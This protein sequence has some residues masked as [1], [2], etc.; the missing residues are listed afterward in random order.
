MSSRSSTVGPVDRDALK[1]LTRNHREGVTDDG[2]RYEYTRPDRDKYPAQFYWDSCFHAFSLARLKPEWARAELRSLVAAQESSGFIGHT[3]FWDAPIRSSRRLFYNVIDGND[4]MTRTIQPP[5]LALAWEAVAQASPDDPGFLAEGIA[6]LIAHYDW[7][8]RER[9]PERVCLLSIIQPDESGLD[10]SP[11]FDALLSWRAAGYP[12]FVALVQRN[13]RDHFELGRIKARNGFVV[14]EVL[15]N[16]A[17]ALSLQALARL[18]GEARFAERAA[19]VRDALIERCYDEQTGLFFDRHATGLQKVSTWTSVA[20][21]ALPDLDP[22][23]AE[24]LIGEHVLNTNEFWLPF[25]I[26]SASASERSFKPFTRLLRYW[27]GPTWMPC[28]WLIH[29]GLGE[30]GRD[31]A[32]QELAGRVATLVARHGFREYYDPYDGRGMGAGHFGMSTLASVITASAS[33]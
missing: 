8:A 33:S 4:R 18:S 22:V 16:V 6:P 17:Y 25:P 3:V 1:I 12:G 2:L 30:H 7:L 20:P 10:A 9:D 15:V 11:K 29:R 14:E 26:P 5:F 31:E 27:R 28:A 24:R 21:L 32:A 19:N 13:R 23:V